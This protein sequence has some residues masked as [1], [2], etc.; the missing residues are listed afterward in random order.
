MIYS[1]DSDDV[2]ETSPGVKAKTRTKQATT[3]KQEEQSVCPTESTA[4]AAAKRGRARN[5]EDHS[6]LSDKD[7][8]SATKEQKDEQHVEVALSRRIPVAK[9]EAAVCRTKRVAP[10][11]KNA[12]SRRKEVAPTAVCVK[13]DP[14]KKKD[15]AAP[16]VVKESSSKKEDKPTDQSEALPKRTVTRRTGPK[17]APEDGELN[18]RLAAVR[19]ATD[20][21]EDRSG[22]RTTRSNRKEWKN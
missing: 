13:K 4:T 14:A 3:K 15:E 2:P 18:S 7:A 16:V 19:I 6:V 20:T 12:P 10:L 8:Q 22:K 5:N 1:S 21:A 17:V 9:R 11:E